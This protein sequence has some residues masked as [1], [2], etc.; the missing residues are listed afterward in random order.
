MGARRLVAAACAAF[1]IHTVHPHIL[2][3]D[4]D[5]GRPMFEPDVFAHA[6]VAQGLV[7]VDTDHGFALGHDATKTP[8][9]GLVVA[10]RREDDRDRLLFDRLDRPPTY[11]YRLEAGA[12]VLTP[13]SP[14]ELGAVLRFEAEAGRG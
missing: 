10:R 9:T 6:S 1:A 13:W 8:A 3:R 12:P 4:R 2:L 14:P 5:G 11:W 7:F